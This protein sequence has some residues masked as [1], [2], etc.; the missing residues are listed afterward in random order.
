[1]SSADPTLADEALNQ[2][3]TIN[4]SRLMMASTFFFITPWFVAFAMLSTLNNN[5]MWLPKGVTHPSMGL[6]IAAV[7]LLV[8]SGLA[9]AWGSVGLKAGSQEQLSRG[10]GLALLLA[11]GAALCYA[12]TLKNMG[13]SFQSGGYANVFFGLTTVYEI[14]L[15]GLCVFLFGIAN[16]ARAGLYTAERMGAVTALTEFWWFYTVL[17]IMSFLLLYVVPFVNIESIA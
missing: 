11:L 1:M 4:L 3:L 17:G 15:V 12:L 2:K 16:R 7:V 9:Y 8:V 14:L 10:A 6:G 13:F 5:Q